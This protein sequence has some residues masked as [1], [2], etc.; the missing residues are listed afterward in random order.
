MHCSCVGGHGGMTEM[1]L[2]VSLYRVHG[3]CI[4]Y[5]DTVDYGSRNADDVFWVPLHLIDA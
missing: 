4:V 2:S 5:E 3:G 1:Y